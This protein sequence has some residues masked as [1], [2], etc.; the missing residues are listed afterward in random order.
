MALLD[1]AMTSFYR[2]SVV[3]SHVF[4]C[5]SLAAIL[6]A[7]FSVL[8]QLLRPTCVELQ[9]RI[10]TF[11]VTFDNAVPLKRIWDCTHFGKSLLSATESRTLAF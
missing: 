10:L 6:N 4:I 9:C 7:F 1:R 11:I 2:L 3:R 5:S 8:N